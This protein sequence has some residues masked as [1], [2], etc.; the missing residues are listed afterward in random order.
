MPESPASPPPEAKY[1]QPPAI[2]LTPIPQ[3]AERLNVVLP[4]FFRDEAYGGIVSA[5]ELAS[6]LARHYPQVRF[7]SQLP[8]GDPGRMFDF[9][10]TAGPGRQ[11]QTVSFAAGEPLACH[12][13]EIFLC[14]HFSTVAVWQAY[15]QA[16]A[17]TG[18]AAAPCYFFAQDY[19][20]DF[21]PP[22]YARDLA[23]AAFAAARHCRTIVN[24]KELA[25]F[26]ANQGFSPDNT[27]VVL[28]SLHPGIRRFMAATGGVLRKPPP[29][30]LTI[31]LY[32]RPGMARNRFEQA[33]Q[34]LALY[35]QAIGPTKARDQVILSAGQAHPDIELAPGVIL[36]S[37]G[38]L[39]MPRYLAL[40]QQAHIGLSLMASPHPSYPPLEMA[41]F[42][43]WV[44]TNRH[45]CKDLSWAHPRIISI[46]RPE[47]LNVAQGLAS[48]RQK[49]LASPMPN[50]ILL[51]GNV[52]PLPWR[53]NLR[54]LDIAPIHAG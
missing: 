46:D 49:A 3:V 50:K 14:T 26:L 12:Q 45:E 8:L 31:L 27:T 42:G 21:Y 48:A 36:K 2:Y 16:L 6:E 39:P 28:P 7:C 15:S 51:P 30:P 40:L 38:K 29:Q 23:L 19:E 52:S 13:A 22:G 20:P 47:P 1:W 10:A 33:V 4:H 43:L 24:S 44:V 9:A 18:L 35:L 17:A 32:G 34:G 11:A 41:A 37:L 53:E 5:M 54:G 25:A